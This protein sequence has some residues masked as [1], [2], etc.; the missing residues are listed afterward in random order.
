MNIEKIKEKA[1]S[2]VRKAGKK[3]VI[4]TMAVIVIGVAVLMNFI[5]SKDAGNT[6]NLEEELTPVAGLLSADGTSAVS[7]E[8]YFAT[9][10]LNRQSARDEAMA[11][12]KTVTESDSAVEEVKNNAYTDIEQ[13]AKDI[14]REANIETLIEAK[15]FEQCVAVVNG[16]SASVI[17]KSPGLTPGEVAQISEIVYNETGIVPTS[18]KIIERN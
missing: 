13:I 5:L 14:E 4:A 2:V 17:I 15:G 11:V 18:L 7:D 3:T 16:D 8:D 10:T 1:A 9:I 12:L 6:K